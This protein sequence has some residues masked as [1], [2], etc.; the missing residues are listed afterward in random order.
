MSSHSS[1]NTSRTGRADV[2]DGLPGY[3]NWKRS[4]EAAQKSFGDSKE[5][6]AASA[7]L[8]RGFV[9]EGLWGWTRHPV[10]QLC[11]SSII[12]ELTLVYYGIE[13]HLR[14]AALVFALPLHS[15]RNHV[16]G[17]H[18]RQPR[19]CEPVYREYS[20][21]RLASCCSVCQRAVYVHFYIE[22][23][24]N[25]LTRSCTSAVRCQLCSLCTS[26]NDNTLCESLLAR[27]P[28]NHLG[29]SRR[30]QYSS[31]IL[32][33]RI[34]AGKYARYAAYQKRVSSPCSAPSHTPKA[35]L[36]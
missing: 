33:E 32:T 25:Q 31:T 10:S 17:C 8:A 20:Y 36:N 3:Q 15:A 21:R 24:G 11:L 35:L 6:K 2:D 1:L 26:G 22:G 16:G 18:W 28:A 27:L 14:A 13:L 4:P 34:S 23:L 9:T 29:L 12:F 30:L 19:C 5:A 7:K